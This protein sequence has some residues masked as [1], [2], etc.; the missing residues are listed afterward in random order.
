MGRSQG[1]EMEALR[2][3]IESKA[4]ADELRAKLAKVRDARKANE[5]KL[6]Q[7]QDELKKVLTSRQEAAAVL[8]G[9]LK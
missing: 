6:V 5:E 9:L 3:A 8:A 1:P 4:S 2:S 7:A